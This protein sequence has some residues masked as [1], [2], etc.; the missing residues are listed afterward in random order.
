MKASFGQWAQTLR[1]L[2]IERLR[3][4]RDEQELLAVIA[5]ALSSS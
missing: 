4:G 2:L 5:I 3:P 1:Q